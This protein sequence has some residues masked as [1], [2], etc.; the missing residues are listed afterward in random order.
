[1][2]LTSCVDTLDLRLLNVVLTK[3]CSLGEN[4]ASRGDGCLEA[5]EIRRPN[6]DMGETGGEFVAL[7]PGNSFVVGDSG[8]SDLDRNRITSAFCRSVLT[9]RRNGMLSCGRRS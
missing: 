9:R 1:M 2:T 8:K 6:S 3:L 4:S 7:F 5:P